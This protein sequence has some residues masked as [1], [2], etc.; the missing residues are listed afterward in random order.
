M[1]CA[2]MEYPGQYRAAGFYHFL[3]D[4]GQGEQL[5]FNAQSP[6]LRFSHGHELTRHVIQGLGYSGATAK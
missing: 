3:P 2:A 1:V 4:R 6:I 5:N